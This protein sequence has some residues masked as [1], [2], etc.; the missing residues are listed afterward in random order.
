MGQAE[1]TGKVN[2][3]MQR[4]E[5]SMRRF[6]MLPEKGG[7]LLC[8]VSGGLDS[9][10]LLH[11]LHTLSEKEG[12]RLAAA[13][14][15]HR[16]RGEASEADAR[17]VEELCAD[18]GIPCVAG[19]G[20]VAAAAEEQGWS[21]EEAARNCRYEFLRRTAAALGAEKIATAHQAE[22]NAETVLLQLLRGS[23]SEGLGGIAPVRD[24]LVRPFLSVTRAEL[25]LYAQ[26]HALP[27][28]EDESN[29]DL[30]F[31]RNRIR[32]A[33]LPELAAINPRAVEAVC[34]AAAVQRRESDLL[35]RIAE[36]EL[37]EIRREACGASAA[38]ERFLRTEPC[39]IPRML[40][41]LLEAAGIGRK[42]ISMRHFDAMEEL[43][44]SGREGAEL[45]LGGGRL[46]LAEG[47]VFALREEERPETAYISPGESV[48]WGDYH[49]SCKKGVE[50]FTE[51]RDTIALKCDMIALPI[52]VGPWDRQLGLTLPGS[53]G[54]RSLKRLFAERGL[55]PGE[56][57]RTPVFYTAGR[58]CAAAE[59]GADEAFLPEKGEE[60]VVLIIEKIER[61]QL[62]K[63]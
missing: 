37:G 47:R 18:W 12:F 52:E 25:E 14:Y 44:F 51:K 23:G 8:A 35:R 43:L 15:N 17:F 61:E 57:E 30:R 22:D 21:L 53:R 36:A 55:S 16:L 54:R 6:G 50:N 48:T 28:R 45:S 27:H 58:L 7:L 5:E 56:R 9:V 1:R 10:C 2:A 11:F 46:R 49:I 41:L 4:A 32:H 40:G 3:A 59:I 13:H 24:E 33:V 39:L 62:W 38:R 20:D 42:D 19:E 34:R 63:T 31:A 60:T 26:Q 29:R